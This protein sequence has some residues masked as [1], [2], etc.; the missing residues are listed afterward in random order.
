VGVNLVPDLV[1]RGF[2]GRQAGGHLQIAGVLR[3]IRGETAAGV[4]RSEWGAGGTVSGVA[5]V[6]FRGLTDRIMFQVNGGLGIARYINDLNSAG[7]MDAVFDT[8]SGD[9]EPLPVIGWF[10]GYEH[11][12]KEWKAMEH[13]NLRSTVLWSVVMVDNVDFQPDDAYRRTHRLASNLVFSP[14]SRADLG[15]EYIFGTRANKD[16]QSANANQFQLVAL[17]RF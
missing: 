4:V 8:T 13:M 2:W 1:A 11:R 7:G 9:L 12:W 17:L 14:T 6:P 15:L 10:V 16:G 3:Q 5:H